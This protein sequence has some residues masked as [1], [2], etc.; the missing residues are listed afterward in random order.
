MESALTT[1]QQQFE[2]TASPGLS[3]QAFELVEKSRARALREGLNDG[4]AFSGGGIPDSIVSLEKSLKADIATLQ[5]RIYEHQKTPDSVHIPRWSAAIF[6]KK[7][8]LQALIL[9]LETSYPDY[10]RLK[11]NTAL[12]SASDIQDQLL[13]HASVHFG[14]FR[15]RQHHFQFYFDQ[16]QSAIAQLAHAER[17]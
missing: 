3:A 9:Q 1:F 15:R 6:D 11:Y 17:F 12:A 10:H 8:A 7:Q 4:L 5:E 13:D 14:I 2:I 16:K